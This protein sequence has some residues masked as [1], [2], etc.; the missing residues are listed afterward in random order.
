MSFVTQ[1]ACLAATA[2]VVQVARAAEWYEEM[3]IGPAWSNT[4]EDNFQGAK[5]VA[6]LKGILLDLGENHRAL[7]DTETLRMVTAYEGK[8]KWGGTPWTGQHGPLISL[9]D[10][11][12]IFNTASIPGWADAA[13]SFE[14]KRE[15][16]GFGNLKHASFKGYYRHGD[17]IVL[18]YNVNG[19]E[20][21]EVVSR[22]GSTIT[23]TFQVS[24]RAKDLVLTVA[25]E[26][27]AFTVSKDKAKSADG[28]G[29]TTTGGVLLTNDLKTPGHLLAKLPKGGAAVFQIAFA[30]G[31]EP[32]ASAAPD[33]KTLIAGG[34]PLYPEIIETKGTVST[35]KDSPYVTDVLGLPEDNPWK[36]NL[37]FGGFDF[38]DEDSA[39]LSS[40]NG[41]V[42]V[43]K[44]LKGD[45]SNLKWQ[46]IASGLF[47]TLG[48]KVVNGI[49]HVNG[50]DQITQLIDLNGDGETDHFKVFNRDVI[51]TPNF[52]EFAFELQTDKGGN[53]YFSKASPVKGGGRGF[54]RI[55]AN[56]GTIV[57]ISPDGK[58]SEVI[59][60]G[61][62]APGGLGVG[63]NGEVTTGENEGTNQPCCKINFMP[64]GSKPLFFGTE[65]SRQFLKNAPYTEPLC[66][67]PMS[68]DNSG[69]SQ[70]WVP[71]GANFGLPT[72]TMLHLSYG[73]STV[74][75]V[76]PVP[77]AKGGIQGGVVKLPITLQSS[78]MRARFQKDGSLYLLGFR[79]WQT[80]A[81]TEC[82]FQ[83][84]RHN[85]E[86]VIPV[87]EKMEYTAK[88][89]RLKFPAKLDK[90]LAE[91][92]TSYGSERWNYVR[93]P[94]YGSGEF[95]VDRPD[96]AAE[97]L[98]LERESKDH[99]KHDTVEIESA[100]L[101]P[102]G[103]TV[104]IELAG[105]KPCMTL[106]VTY[107]LEDTEGK[108]MAGAMYGTVYK[109]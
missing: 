74:Y 38:I 99:N 6:A 64:G 31:A 66:Y 42:W 48:V 72:G 16:P 71:D 9:N 57:K 10:D 13:G 20:I 69:A 7:F 88:G 95:S 96:S 36:S 18:N 49:I 73:Q 54:D 25:D 53:F 28:L 32:T 106:K 78:A 102:D 82:A 1:L 56:N 41:D 59:A 29:V 81:A 44:G 89:I 39:A 109:D 104:E 76:L 63:P 43:V 24:A 85:A 34:A 30:R 17:K 8:W 51:I 103:Q 75:K 37:R 33:F 3:K 11:K 15:T 46:R 60:T 107:D 2:T 90:E 91:D 86:A 23:R 4:F 12:A 62:R 93:G 79:G 14:D 61:L 87:P 22:E 65:A 68:V 40:W 80:N 55:L 45:W 5:R 94:Q 47:E 98:A 108:V 21:L 77:R 100:R 101:L 83:R 70:V 26:K 67:L 35:D 27:G 50:R 52:H 105:M 58:K 84:V 19:S 97:K 92:P